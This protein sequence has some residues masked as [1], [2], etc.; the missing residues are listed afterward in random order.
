MEVSNK[1]LAALLVLSVL[2]SLAGMYTAIYRIQRISVIGA[3][4]SDTATATLNISTSQAIQFTV[5]TVDWDTGYVNTTGGYNNCTL[6][7][8]T[9][10]QV[11]CIGFRDA[12]NDPDYVHSLIL[13][14]V[15]TALVNVTLNSSTDAATLL[16][17][18][19]PSIQWKLDYN[20]SGSC[21]ALYDTNW[22][23]VNTTA[24]LICE[25][26]NYV[27]TNDSIKVDLKIRIPYDSSTGLKTLTLTAA[28]QP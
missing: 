23:E 21:S 17:G 28:I 10:P 14:N 26:F 6:Y 24:E 8:T 1:T 5:A 16:G 15:G 11:G 2:V 4:T 9:D 7:T 3:A 20:E 18:T 27:D 19:N 25:D 12:T 13:E 22:D